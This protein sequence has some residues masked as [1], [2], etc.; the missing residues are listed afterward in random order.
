MRVMARMLRGGRRGLPHL[1]RGDSLE[2]GGA[3][4]DEVL[5]DLRHKG[6]NWWGFSPQLWSLKLT[7]ALTETSGIALPLL[8]HDR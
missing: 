7:R 5:D 6:A 2:N 8:W 4:G 1:Q 3:A